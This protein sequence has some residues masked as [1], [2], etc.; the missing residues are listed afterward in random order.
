MNA[1]VRWKFWKIN[2]YRIFV[3]FTISILFTYLRYN[4]ACKICIPQGTV[5]N[6]KSSPHEVTHALVD[7]RT[8][9]RHPEISLIIVL[10]TYKGINLFLQKKI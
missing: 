5:R 6:S 2:R 9:V 3:F 8:V 4:V 1:M 10:I 7:N